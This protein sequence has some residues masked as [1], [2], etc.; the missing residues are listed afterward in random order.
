MVDR[1]AALGLFRKGTE[2]GEF[3]EYPL[4]R[5]T[6]K[7]LARMRGEPNAIH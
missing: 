5:A 7:T 6:L 2:E 3:P 4:C 1:W